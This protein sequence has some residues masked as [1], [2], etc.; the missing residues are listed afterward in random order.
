MGGPLVRAALAR[1]GE[2]VPVDSEHSAALQCLGG[3]PPREVAAPD[4]DRLGR[5]AARA[6]RLAPGHAGGGAGAP[7]VEHGAAHHGGL[8]HALQQGARADRGA[9]P[10]RA[11]LGAA[12]RRAA[13]AD[14]RARDGRVPRRLDRGAGR[15]PRHAAAHPARAVVAGALGRGGAA[16]GAGARWPGSSSRRSRRAAS[17]PS[18]WRW[19]RAARAAPRRACSTRPTRSRCRRSST[20]SCRWAGCRGS[21]GE[22]LERHRPEPVESLEQLERVDAWARQTARAAAE[23]R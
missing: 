12:R 15:R 7:G 1:G 11:R 20:A 9:G 17:R 4:A 2:L 8:G 3:R 21:S 19:R 10:V 14:D 18:T 13:P 23:A 22:V 16:A 5:G 6:P